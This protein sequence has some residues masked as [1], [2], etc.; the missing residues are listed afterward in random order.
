ME[1]N[2][3]KAITVL[4]SVYNEKK[5]FLEK[6]I[7]S[8]LGQTF[9]NF[10]FLLINDCSTE[11]SCRDILASY[12]T[13][14][15]RIKLIENERNLGLTKSLNKG[16]NVATGQYIARI[17]S[18]DVADPNRLEKQLRFMQKNSA[19]ALCGS[20]AYLID[21]N[22]NIT[23][24]KKFS[25][26]YQAIKK[27]LVFFN[28]FTHSSLFF[29]KNIALKNGGYNEKMKKA[30][31]YDFILKISARNPIAN[32]PEFL[33][34]YRTHPGSISSKM[35]KR[36]EWYALIARWRAVWFYGYPKKDLLKIIPAFFYFLFVPC[37]LENKLLKSIQ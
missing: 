8:I 4:M 12:A 3:L 22:G 21:E 17:D 36:Q 28:F 5:E 37:F 11:K 2:N 24:E 6:S 14:D 1:K 35:K 29:K 18:D 23:G 26:D 32:I 7:E 34:F 27:K 15:E 10:E 19:Y 33:C 20:W 25:T 30:Q 9:P 31:D 13:K 16:L